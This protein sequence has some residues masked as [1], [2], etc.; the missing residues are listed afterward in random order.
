VRWVRYHTYLTHLT[1]IASKRRNNMTSEKQ[2]V[3]NKTNALKSTGP[4]SLSGKNKAHQNSLKHGLLSRDLVIRDEDPKE[5]AAMINDLFNTLQP[6]GIME[7]LLVEKIGAALWRLRRVISAE[8]CALKGNGWAGRLEELQDVYNSSAIAS[9]SRYESGMERNFYKAL[10]E[11][12]R[13]QAMR[14]GGLALA[15]VAVD[16]HGAG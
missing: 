2:I 16:I 11:L 7:G 12:Q 13:M 6:E 5:W 4:R 9:I 8:G 15:P 1:I 14:L 10:H 3:A